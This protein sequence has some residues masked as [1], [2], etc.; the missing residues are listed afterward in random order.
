MVAQVREVAG[1]AATL[2]NNMS[3]KTVRNDDAVFGTFVHAQSMAARG[4][5]RLDKHLSSQ[6]TFDF[7]KEGWQCDV[8]VQ[9]VRQWIREVAVYVGAS[10]TKLLELMAE[11]LVNHCK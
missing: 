4:L 10:Q 3:T 1:I 5:L 11:T 9:S 6:E 2:H 8:N 7:E